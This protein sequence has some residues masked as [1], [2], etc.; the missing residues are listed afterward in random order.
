VQATDAQA[1]ADTATRNL[2]IAVAAAPQPDPLVIT[3]TSLPNARRNKNYSATLAATGGTTPYT[4]SVVVGTLPPGLSLNSSTGAITGRASALGT[5]SFTV[6]VRDSQ[7]TPGTTSK[8][9]SITVKH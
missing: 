4:W 2:S 8:A 1:P 9:F 3:T 5:W 7:S 6:Q